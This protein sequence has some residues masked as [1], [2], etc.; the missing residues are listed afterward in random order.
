M[1]LLC[2]QYAGYMNAPAKSYGQLASQY[3]LPAI[4]AWSHLNADLVCNSLLCLVPLP[5]YAASPYPS[6]HAGGNVRRML[7][8]LCHSTM[9]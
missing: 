7:N 2:D 5:G 1:S 4:M 6:K 3:M 9:V 8:L